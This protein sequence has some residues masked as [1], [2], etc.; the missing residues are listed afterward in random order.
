MAEWGSSQSVQPMFDAE[1]GSSGD[2]CRAAGDRWRSMN[3]FASM[4]AGGV[5]LAFGSDSPVTALG[6]HGRRC[7]PLRA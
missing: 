7:A 2:K 3:P 1:W 4:Q 5:V 6:P